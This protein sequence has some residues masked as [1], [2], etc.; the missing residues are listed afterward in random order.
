MLYSFHAFLLDDASLTWDVFLI[1]VFNDVSNVDSM[2]IINGFFSYLMVFAASGVDCF[3]E[4]FLPSF[5]E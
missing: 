3:I 1:T 2:C 5:I 4:A